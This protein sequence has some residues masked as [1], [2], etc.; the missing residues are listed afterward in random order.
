MD[1]EAEGLLEGLEGEERNARKKL[2]EQLSE[3]GVPDGELKKAVEEQRLALLPVER[4]LG[5]NRTLS[6]EEAGEK[7]GVSVEFVHRHRRALGLPLNEDNGKAFSDE[8]VEALEDVK[9]F[10]DAGLDEEGIEDVTR[11]VGESMSRVARSVAELTANSLLRPGVTEHDLGVGFAE[12]AR[13]L[14]PLFGKQLEFVFKQQLLELVR[15]EMVSHSERESG[16]LPGSETVNVSFADL[17]GFT[18]LGEELPPE[19]I[20]RV[21]GK[22][23]ELAADLAEP[24]VRLVKTIGDAAMLVSPE[25]STEALVRV[26]LDL[27][28]AVE[29]EGE[30]F[31]MLRA[32]V[33][34]GE[35]I[36][37]GGDW[38]GRPVNVASR[39]TGVARPGSVLTTESVH[40]ET[41]DAFTWSFA[42]K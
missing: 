24:P 8:D 3:D 21:A 26:T 29:G 18:K 36:G 11:V 5:A 25:G 13:H 33:A 35:A 41:E 34:R 10:I 23:G 17:V 27:I 1:F 12:A 20:G 4:A 38:Y 31:P 42:G 15:S 2:L 6:A 7:A 39:L 37:R 16:R 14:V 28:R 19:E 32:G 9:S 40:D 30:D 22:L